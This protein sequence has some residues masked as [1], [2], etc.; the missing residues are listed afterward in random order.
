MKAIIPGVGLVILIGVVAANLDRLG[1]L[2]ANTAEVTKETI[3]VEVHPEWATD[4]DA[5]KA[6]QD[7]VQRKEWEAELNTVQSEIEALRARESEL[8]KNLNLH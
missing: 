7:V 8:E 1:E 5:V 4:E 3:A 2:L 6:A